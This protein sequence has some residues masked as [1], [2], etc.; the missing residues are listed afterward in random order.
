MENKDSILKKALAKREEGGLA[1]NF[2]Y[3]MME[4]VRLEAE[5]KR[6]RQKLILVSA[7]TAASLFILALLVYFIFFYLKI[8]TANYLPEFK[9][10]SLQ[11]SKP[12]FDFYWYI[13]GI[14]IVL[15]GLDYWLRKKQK[16][17]SY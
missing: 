16:K 1:F 14:A 6:K 8:N 10:E 4:K 12:I 5:K 13:G 2:S 15:L 11:A 7:L 3:R 9:W 17:N